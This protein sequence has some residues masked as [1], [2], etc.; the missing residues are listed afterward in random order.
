[1]P[2]PTDIHLLISIKKNSTS[3]L[4]KP[5]LWIGMFLGPQDPDPSSFCTDPNPDLDLN[6]SITTQKSKKKP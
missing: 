5:V 4:L 6:H 2:L 1:V 3:V